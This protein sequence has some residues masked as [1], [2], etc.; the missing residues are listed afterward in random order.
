M[1]Q[2]LLL[3]KNILAN[4]EL[5]NKLQ[6]LNDEVWCSNLLLDQIQRFGVPVFVSQQFQ[7]IIF[8]KTICDDEAQE[9]LQA[10]R[11]YPLMILR[12]VEQ[13]PLDEERE[14]WTERGLHGYLSENDTQEM[15]REKIALANQKRTQTTDLKKRIVPFPHS[16][17]K[18]EFDS[19]R[20]RLT[21]KEQIVM[22]LLVRAQ[23]EIMTRQELCEK[24]W[25]DGNTASNMSQLS[26]MINRIKRKFENQGVDGR[27]IITHWGRGYQ[28]SEYFYQQCSDY[29]QSFY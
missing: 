1:C 27:I 18:S 14:K 9:L 4:Q 29:A 23:G 6:G 16:D 10:L 19:S 26:C 7:L 8:G 2:A 12:E 17:T 3:T 5:Q 21:G 25:S 20:I 11:D 24:I 13:E 15:I 28:L 22:N